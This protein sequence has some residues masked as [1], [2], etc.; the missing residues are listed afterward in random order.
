MDTITL[1]KIKPLLPPRAPDMH[2]GRAGRVLV[3]AGSPGMAGAAVL[4]AG[5]ALRGGAGLVYVSADESLWPILQTR[6][7]C[8][9]CVRRSGV[10]A[11]RGTAE[12]TRIESVKT[13]FESDAS[14]DGTPPNVS[15]FDSYDA[16]A[17][18]PGLGTSDEAERLIDAILKSYAGS[19]VID[20]DA[21]NLLARS[22][23]A[24]LPGNSGNSRS[25]VV[26]PHPGEAARLLGVSVAD[27]QSD[28]RRAAGML[29]E[30]Y[31]AVAVLK[32]NGTLVAVPSRIPPQRTDSAA[33]GSSSAND[34]TV[35]K[36]KA[37]TELFE[38]TTGNPGM[39]TAGSGDA[40][41]GL[42]ASFAAQGMSAK[43]AALAGVFIHGLAGDMAVNER[44]EYGL[45]ATD[46][47]RYLPLA[48]KRV[49]DEW[50]EGQSS[51]Q[52]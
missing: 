8:A 18:G 13:L 23:C 10:E 39:A 17:V 9:I 19:L 22:R 29:A 43:D 7:P 48:I 37:A 6:E 12:A 35:R 24:A 49:T 42:I 52:Q 36:N 51:D 28:R 32:G 20:A 38:N 34:F 4:A 33:S 5:A 25:V 27:V 21:L 11:A 31:S 2:K 41:T 47:V 50:R 46:I 44:G 15:P 45:V 16:L 3:V 30:K 1:E 14:A 40:L 26:T